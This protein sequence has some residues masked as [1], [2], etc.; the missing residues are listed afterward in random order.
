MN[1]MRELDA[2]FRV[3]GIIPDTGILYHPAIVN[4]SWIVLAL[5]LR[6]TALKMSSI[7]ARLAYSR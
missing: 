4:E 7:K 3:S 6:Q 1:N 5:F 2:V